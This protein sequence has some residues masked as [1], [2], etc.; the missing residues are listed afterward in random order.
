[1]PTHS[2]P[3]TPFSRFVDVSH[4][5]L[6]GMITYKGLPSPVIRDYLS[7]EESRARYAE[8][9]EFC[10][11]KIEMVG[12]TGT[13]VDSPYHRYRQGKDLSELPLSSLANLDGV[14][15][16]QTRTAGRAID[17]SRLR[18]IDVRGKAVLIHTGWDTFWGTEEYFKGNP[19]LT[20]AGA[21]SL[22]IGGAVLVGID[23]LN[24]DNTDDPTRPAHSILL[25]ADIP[26]VEHLCNLAEL[27]EQGFTFFAVPVKVNRLGTFPV[28]AFA[29]VHRSDL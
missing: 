13:Y 12:H 9:V 1:M 16:R 20:R 26:I 24:I 21:E 2:N 8:G 27:P 22:A 18:G 19:F 25:G 29:M 28:R 15:V 17:A 14:V 3:R 10:L 4:P 11:G 7:H 5:L 6:D 23:S